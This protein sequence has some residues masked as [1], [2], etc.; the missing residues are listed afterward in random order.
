MQFSGLEASAEQTDRKQRIRKKVFF[1]FFNGWLPHFDN[2]FFVNIYVWK[3]KYYMHLCICE[4]H[5]TSDLMRLTARTNSNPCVRM[6]ILWGFSPATTSLFEKIWWIDWKARF[7]GLSIVVGNLGAYDSCHNYDDYR[8][9]YIL[10]IFD[11][12]SSEYYKLAGKLRKPY[13]SSLLS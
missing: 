4:W 10:Y 13:F 9:N 5:A 12:I 1:V 2:A 3:L 8:M 6:H 11:I 7:L